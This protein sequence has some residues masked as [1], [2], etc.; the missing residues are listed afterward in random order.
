VTWHLE[1][2]AVMDTETTAPNPEEARLVSAC[3][4]G[5]GPD[6]ADVKQSIV[7]P[8]VPIPAEASA[9]HGISDERAREEGCEPGEACEWLVGNLNQ[10]WAAGVPVVAYNASYDFTVLDR[11]CRRHLGHGLDING[12]IVDPYV[13]DREVD[14][15]RKGKRILSVTAQHYGVRLGEAHDA[16]EDALAA[17]RIAWRICQMYPQIAA[18]SLES[19]HEAQAKWHRAR[20]ESF[21]QHR[22]RIGEPVNDVCGDWP[23]RPI[24]EGV[25]A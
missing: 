17:G 5:V 24:R 12:P 6:G 21:K 3:I 10:F 11:E 25:P 16:T 8:G 18:M 2:F 13:I 19:L 15:Y 4:G 7:N 9:I 1:P 22:A 23:L 20:Q 14:M